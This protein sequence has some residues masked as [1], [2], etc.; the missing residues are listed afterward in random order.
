MSQFE[1]MSDH[2]WILHAEHEID[3]PLLAA[4]VGEKRTL[5]MDA[6]AS[7]AHAAEFRAHLAEQ[8]LRLPELVVL[9]HWHW[10]H[11]FGL[12]EWKIPAIAVPETAQRLRLLKGLD[13]SDEALHELAQQQIIN[14]TSAS[15]IR[16]EYGLERN[17]DIVEPDI[18]FEQKLQLDLGGVVCDI[19]HVG[20]DHAGDSCILYVRED[21]ALFLG[22]ALGPSVYGGPRTY[23]SAHFLRLMDEVYRYGAEIYVE[24]HSVPVSE[25]EFRLDIGR[26]AE[27]ARLV[28]QHGKDREGITE[29]M[30][31][32]LQVQE[33]PGEFVNAMEWFLTP[34]A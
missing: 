10:D 14:E 12:S 25:E 11:T 4:V 3:R 2:I 23:T 28:D 31:Q 27:L 6:G 33:L 34:L 18:L 7:P 21:K 16:L 29:G 9:T 22:D 20:G 24:S 26:Y 1:Q 17:I 30:K 5:L 13:W 15:H 19:H 32:F 8:G